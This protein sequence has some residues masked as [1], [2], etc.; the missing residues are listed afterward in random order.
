MRR[1]GVLRQALPLDGERHDVEV[2]SLLASEWRDAE[3][4]AKARTEQPS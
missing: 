3:T 1:D 4:R 2:W